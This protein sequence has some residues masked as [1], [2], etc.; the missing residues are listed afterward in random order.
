MTLIQD[1]EL[2]AVN[3]E[4]K[5]ILINGEKPKTDA[6]MKAYTKQL[7]AKTQQVCV[8]LSSFKMRPIC[9]PLGCESV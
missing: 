3:A 1:G 2:Q 7:A 6:Q 8:C 4:L 9:S 5:S